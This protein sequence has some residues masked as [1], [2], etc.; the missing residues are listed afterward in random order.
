MSIAPVPWLCGVSANLTF[1]TVRESTNARHIRAH[2]GRV[3]QRDR[4][5]R[6]ADRDQYRACGR[7]T[8]EGFVLAVLFGANLSCATPM[9]YKANLLVFA[10]DGYRFSDF[11]RGGLPLTLIMWLALSLVLAQLDVR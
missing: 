7:R 11:V 8:S 2:Q 4:P 5:D 9:A 3:E 1:D 10:A 6:H